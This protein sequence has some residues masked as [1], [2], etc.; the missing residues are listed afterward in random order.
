MRAAG[1]DTPI[2]MLR[3][4]TDQMPPEQI[5]W[6]AGARDP[7]VGGALALMHRRPR[8]P[9]TIAELAV[10]IGASRSVVVDRFVRLKTSS[11]VKASRTSAPAFAAASSSNLSRIFRRGQNATAALS[12][13]GEPEIVK[14][15]K[16]KA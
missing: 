12:A 1:I 5:G 6:L 8:H 10:E 15:P 3:R 11:T 7:I 13:P 2:L 16:S 9:W 14:G 4:Y